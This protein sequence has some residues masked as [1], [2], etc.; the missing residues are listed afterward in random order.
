[1]EENLES[2]G[3]RRNRTRSV[4]IGIDSRQPLA[5]TVMRYS[6][7]SNASRPI[8]VNGLFLHQL[9]ISRVGA[10]EFSYSRFL[11]PWLM[12][13]EGF[14]LFCDE[15]QVM[16]GD[17]WELFSYCS[18]L[19]DP[20]DVAVM[21]NQ[22][23]Y[24]WPSVMVFNNQNLKHM[25]PEYIEDKSNRFFDFAWAKHV[26]ELPPEWN[27]FCGGARPKDAKLY[28]FSQ[29]IPYW[30]ETRGLDEDPVWFE[31]FENTMKAG[32]WIDFHKDTIH[33]MPVMERYLSSNYGLKLGRKN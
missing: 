3:A 26:A 7:E 29:G 5:Y 11:V 14:G 2:N 27:H 19:D 9:P 15:D 21:K 16:T 4:Y 17:V 18:K 32:K 25:T 24:E 8:S 10:T 28:H 6:V 13:F 12:D 33:F 22:P 20:W 30:P 1:L 31:A 23:E